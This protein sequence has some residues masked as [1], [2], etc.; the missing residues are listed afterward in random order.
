MSPPTSRQAE[1]ADV[2]IDRDTASR[3]GISTRDV[4]DALYSSFGQRQISTIFTQLNQYHVVLE[5]KPEFRCSPDALT[6]VYVPGSDG[7]PV[8]LQ[9]FTKVTTASTPLT[10]SRRIASW[11]WQG[12]RAR[13]SPWS[14]PSSSGCGSNPSW[15]PPCC[16]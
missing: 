2:A 12:T 9:A 8:P 7:R 5:V 6:N 1:S 15:M 11:R 16:C 13:S 3:F 14:S 4:D 10:V